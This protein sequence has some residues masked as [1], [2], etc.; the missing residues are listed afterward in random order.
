MADGQTIGKLPLAAATQAMS[1]HEVAGVLEQV[2]STGTEKG[3][4][5]A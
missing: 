2:S 3:E 1:P 4:Y 5:D